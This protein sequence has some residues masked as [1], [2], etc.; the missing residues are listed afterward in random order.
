MWKDRLENDG[1]VG[2]GNGESMGEFM[3]G[4]RIP[5][6]TQMNQSLLQKPKKYTQSQWK[7]PRNPDLSE[8]FLWLCARVKDCSIQAGN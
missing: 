4:F 6:P 2:V 8:I 1:G 7:P 5:T 3:R